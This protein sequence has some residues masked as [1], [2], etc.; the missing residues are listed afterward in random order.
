MAMNIYRFPLLEI[1]A[2]D[3]DATVRYISNHLSLSS[4]TN[5]LQKLHKTCTALRQL[6]NTRDSTDST[7]K[8]GSLG[9]ES[10]GIATLKVLLSATDCQAL[11]SYDVDEVDFRFLEAITSASPRS[12]LANFVR[13][14]TEIAI[15]FMYQDPEQVAQRASWGAAIMRPTQW[16]L[17]ASTLDVHRIIGREAR[18]E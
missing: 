10:F 7:L 14:A 8:Y 17:H 18:S 12:E 3:S 13:W 4:L 15:G 11:F 5:L 16:R 6:Y 2:T 1:P 9:G